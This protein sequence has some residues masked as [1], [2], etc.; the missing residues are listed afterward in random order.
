MRHRIPP[1]LLLTGMLGV[2]SG[3]AGCRSVPDLAGPIRSG[4][5]A[6]TEAALADPTADPNANWQGTP[7]L[8]TAAI[9]AQP[10]NRTAIVRLLLQAGADP[11]VVG[12]L[13][14]DGPPATPL[15]FAAGQGD[16][17]LVEL[18]LASGADP[19]L[20]GWNGMTALIEAARMGQ[21][22]ILKLLLRSG[23]QVDQT[24]GLGHTALAWA[25]LTGRPESV[26]S[27][28]RQGGDPR[29]ADLQGRTP[30]DHARLRNRGELLPLLE[31]R[32]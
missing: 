26:R 20:A 1:V 4:D 30:I 24:D 16:T 25:A 7:L 22:E 2:S 32:R 13:P 3:L 10:A 14:D 27:L 19:D 6:A 18:L 5:V 17:E 31:S 12:N 11:N 23:A 29:L 8:L 9:H 28:M 15:I 21:V